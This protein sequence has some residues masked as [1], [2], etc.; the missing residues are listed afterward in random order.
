MCARYNKPM[1]D[2]NKKKT[3]NKENQIFILIESIAL[4]L[5]LI[6]RKEFESQLDKI[7][8]DLMLSYISKHPCKPCVENSIFIGNSNYWETI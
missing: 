3:F 5:L 1:L 4:F 7:P 8:F 2:I 6:T